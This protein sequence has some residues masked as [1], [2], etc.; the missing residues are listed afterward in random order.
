MITRSGAKAKLESRRERRLERLQKLALRDGIT[1]PYNLR[2]TMGRKGGNSS[3]VVTRGE[4]GDGDAF[5]EAE[6]Q[7]KKLQFL[8]DGG[9]STLIE[10]T[11]VSYVDM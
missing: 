8:A 1:T 9:C 4:V 10:T 3:K 11:K 6:V 5:D 2:S 7:P